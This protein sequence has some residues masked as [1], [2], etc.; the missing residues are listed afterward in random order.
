MFKTIGPIGG[1]RRARTLQSSKIVCHLA[2]SFRERREHGLQRPVTT[3]WAEHVHH[4][5]SK[6][7]RGTEVA[8][9]FYTLIETAKLCGVNPTEYLLEAARAADRGEILLPQQ[10]KR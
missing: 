10:M 2:P 1:A 4:F 6:S 8:A 5:G 3:G 7:E 9:T